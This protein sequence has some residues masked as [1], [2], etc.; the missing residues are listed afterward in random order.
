MPAAVHAPASVLSVRAAADRAVA[1]PDFAVIDL[2]SLGLRAHPGK[3]LTRLLV[4][5]TARLFQ[6]GPFHFLKD[7][8]CSSGG[9]K[10]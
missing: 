8:F 3:I 6:G 4:A 2:M 1:V 7:A 9:G 10:T 5:T